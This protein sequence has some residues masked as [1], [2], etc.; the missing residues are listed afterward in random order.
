[1]SAIAVETIEGKPHNLVQALGRA[2]ARWPSANNEN[3]DLSRRSDQRYVGG[4]LF[5]VYSEEG[6]HI[7]IAFGHFECGVRVPINATV[8]FSNSS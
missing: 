3:I 8:F 5:I 7:H 2:Q 6:R 4:G 1:M